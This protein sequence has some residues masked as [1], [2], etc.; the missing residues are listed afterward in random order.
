M[1]LLG[2]RNQP[3]RRQTIIA[4][5]AGTW[6]QAGEI[7]RALELAAQVPDRLFASSPTSPPNALR[8]GVLQEIAAA[9]VRAAHR[10]QAEATFGQALQL[11]DGWNDPLLRAQALH[12]IARAEAAAGMK[13]AADATL[14]RALQVV[15]TVHVIGEKGVTLLLLALADLQMRAGLAAEETLDE[16]LAAEHDARSGRAEWRLDVGIAVQ[17]PGNYLL[18]C[19]IAKA[20]A[21]AGLPVKTA[22]TFDEALQAA[23]AITTRFQVRGDVAVASALAHVADA[24]LEAGLVATARETLDRAAAVA[25]V[26]TNNRDL[27]RVLPVLAEVRTKAG[28]ATPDL[29]ARSLAVARALPDDRDRAHALQLAA[30]AQANAGLRNEAAR[31]F[32]EAARTVAQDGQMLSS[33]ADAQRGTGF[34]AEAALTF[35]QALAVTLSGDEQ[36]K[37]DRVASL[38]RTIAR[39]RGPALAAAAPTLRLRL[40]D[41][42]EAVPDRMTR[43][44]MLSIIART[45]PN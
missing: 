31:T 11:A 26:I 34:I 33:I 45:L 1:E 41:A 17:N 38:I 9:Q 16:A 15:A 30:R 5:I 43:A 25:G 21:R 10:E 35:D 12:A 28:D 42:A 36:E 2:P 37:G 4:A 6:A 8:I 32:A 27:A 24:E 29:F 20:Q 19:D 44:D 3:G 14:D 7:D 39:Y 13:A 40:V 22:G 18:L 23:Q